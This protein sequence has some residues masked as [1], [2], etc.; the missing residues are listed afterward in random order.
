M[1][2][3]RHW[4]APQAL[5]ESADIFDAPCGYAWAELDRLG[6]SQLTFRQSVADENGKMANVAGCGQ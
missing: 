1:F 2:P 4:S 6:K 5:D 3:I